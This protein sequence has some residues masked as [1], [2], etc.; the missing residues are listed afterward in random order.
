MTSK[1]QEEIE[2]IARGGM[3]L[4][5]SILVLDLFRTHVGVSDYSKENAAQDAINHLMEH[6]EIMKIQARGL[7]SYKFISWYGFFL[8]NHAD[9]PKNVI[10]IATILALNIM[11]RRDNDKSLPKD[12][13]SELAAMA[14]RDGQDDNFGIGK[15]GVYFIFKTCSKI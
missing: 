5:D 13:L 7:D 8:S 11:L 15:N 14:L 6:L 1:E 3:Q 10:R 9:D 2:A 4:I 12:L